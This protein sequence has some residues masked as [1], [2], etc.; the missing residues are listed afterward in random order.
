MQRV[1]AGARFAS[2]LVFPLSQK[3]NPVEELC[4]PPASIGGDWSD[5]A[6]AWAAAQHKVL[7]TLYHNE[8][9][10]VYAKMI[11]NGRLAKFKSGKVFNF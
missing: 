6:S 1:T 11:L 7:R 10:E 4:Q 9:V 8:P 5:R 2:L 3:L